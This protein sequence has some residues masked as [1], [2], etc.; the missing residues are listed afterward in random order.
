MLVVFS[1]IFVVDTKIVFNNNFVAPV[2]S[3]GT[4]EQ[5]FP[6]AALN[7]FSGISSGTFFMD[8]HVVSPPKSQSRSIS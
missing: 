6:S 1:P 7:R 8:L 2:N 5:L 3:T 4:C